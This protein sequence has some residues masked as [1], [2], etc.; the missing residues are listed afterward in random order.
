MAAITNAAV[1]YVLTT[2]ESS[3]FGPGTRVT[4]VESPQLQNTN[5]FTFTVAHGDGDT[6]SVSMTYDEL[7]VE[8]DRKPI[9]F[10]AVITD[11]AAAYDAPYG[12]LTVVTTEA[13]LSN[14]TTAFEQPITLKLASPYLVEFEITYDK[15]KHPT[16]LQAAVERAA[17]FQLLVNALKTSIGTLKTYADTLTALHTVAE[18]NELVERIFALSEQAG[19]LSRL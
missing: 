14:G 12:P 11:I 2:L 17:G 7:I 15:M 5:D 16:Y 4:D 18:S 10:H 3:W 8:F 1:D 6:T 19:H 13:Q 9:I